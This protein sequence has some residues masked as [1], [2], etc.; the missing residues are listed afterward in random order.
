MRNFAS[1]YNKTTND[2]LV[3]FRDSHDEAWAV[4]SGP[5]DK[6]TAKEIEEALQEKAH[7]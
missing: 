1:L 4:H 2:Y 7:K 6:N 3:I 5:F